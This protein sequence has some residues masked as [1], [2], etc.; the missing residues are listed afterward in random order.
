MRFSGLLI[1]EKDKSLMF[2]HVVVVVGVKGNI[3]P[4]GFVRDSLKHFYARSQFKY[5]LSILPPLHPHNS[6]YH[7]RSA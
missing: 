2:A 7:S 6:T 3:V 5:L 4:E 1:S